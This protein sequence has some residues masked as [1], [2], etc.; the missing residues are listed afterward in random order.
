MTPVQNELKLEK[1][2]DE[3]E[4]QLDELER[5]IPRPAEGSWQSTVPLCLVDLP[6]VRVVVSCV[7]STAQG[8]LLCKSNAILSLMA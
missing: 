7:Q 1:K 6:A 3:Q 8:E 2:L 5:M 4:T